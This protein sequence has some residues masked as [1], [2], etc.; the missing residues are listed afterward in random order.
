MNKRSFTRGVSVPM[1]L[2]RRLE[3]DN[4]LNENF[5]SLD[6]RIQTDTINSTYLPADLAHIDIN[7]DG[8]RYIS[9]SDDDFLRY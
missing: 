8:S 1:Y 5:M 9:C 6:K 3:C 4:T 2:H 7:T